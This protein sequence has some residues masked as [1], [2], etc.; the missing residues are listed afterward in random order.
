MVLAGGGIRGGQVVGESD[1]QA[2]YPITRPV[3]PADIHATVFTAL[4]YDPHATTYPSSDG[5][6]IPLSEGSAIGE[7][8]G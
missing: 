8:L 6:P 7:L 4:G 5:R 3:T 1:E 2:A